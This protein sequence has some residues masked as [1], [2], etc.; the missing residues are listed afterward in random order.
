MLTCET[1][2]TC[3]VI[4]P[5]NESGALVLGLGGWAKLQDF[6]PIFLFASMGITI[7]LLG[8]GWG[9]AVYPVHEPLVAPVLFQEE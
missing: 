6:E 4:G 9:S 3:V 1:A 8:V 7:S 5:I 2:S